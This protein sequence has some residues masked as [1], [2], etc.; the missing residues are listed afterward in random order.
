MNKK[1]A[2]IF[3]YNEYSLEIA[4]NIKHKYP[5]ITI[6]SSVT[7]D[8]YT[9]EHCD[10]EVEHFDLSDNW[11]YLKNNYDLDE[12]ICFCSLTDEAENIF[13]V[14]NEM[15]IEDTKDSINQEA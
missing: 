15:C 9:N 12:I 2:L 10:Y 7:H 5:N 8:D 13:L 4:K 1:S 14:R 3:G 6:F 11:D